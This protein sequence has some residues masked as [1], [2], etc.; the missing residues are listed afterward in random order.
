M[1]VSDLTTQ[2]PDQ[3]NRRAAELAEA[4]WKITSRSA[5]DYFWANR[6]TSRYGYAPTYPAAVKAAHAKMKEGE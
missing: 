5:G 1:S 2:T 6:N 3:L 4:G